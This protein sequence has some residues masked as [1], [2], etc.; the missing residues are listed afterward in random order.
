MR[1]PVAP[2]DDMVGYEL[3]QIG[4]L[5]ILTAPAITPDDEIPER[6][7]PRNAHF[8][9]PENLRNRPLSPVLIRP[10]LHNHLTHPLRTHDPHNLLDVGELLARFGQEV[11]IH[12]HRLGLLTLLLDE[13]GPDAW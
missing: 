3:V 12:L 13:T 6:L 8:E 9:S 1:A 2:T 10:E 5:A 11:A 7:M 4:T